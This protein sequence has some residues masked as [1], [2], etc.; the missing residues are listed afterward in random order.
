M[1]KLWRVLR[2]AAV[3]WSAAITCDIGYF[4]GQTDRFGSKGSGLR[5]MLNGRCLGAMQTR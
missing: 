2:L 3:V 1:L 5:T 4:Q